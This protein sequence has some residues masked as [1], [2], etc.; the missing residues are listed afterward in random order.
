MQPTTSRT[1]TPTSHGSKSRAPSQPPISLS[2]PSTKSYSA[3]PRRRRRALILPPSACLFLPS[4]VSIQRSHDRA[5]RCWPERSKEDRAK[6]M[7]PPPPPLGLAA[8]PAPAASGCWTPQANQS[9]NP[10]YYS[11]P[12]Q[13]L[14]TL[15]MREG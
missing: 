5:G 4:S 7:V 15:S 11:S 3:G 13:F 1:R 9:V 12:T 2:S 14:Q 8:S 6:R 10:W